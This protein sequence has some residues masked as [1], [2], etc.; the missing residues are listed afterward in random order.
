MHNPAPVQEND[1]HK[2]LWDFY[3][4]TDHLIS[5]IRP[6]KLVI[7]KKRICKIV[8]FA[9][10]ADLRIKLREYEKKAK[11]LDLAWESKE[12][13]E[14]KGDYYINRYWYFWYSN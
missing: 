14:H 1:T 6:H 13:V 10:P 5:T 8:E 3:I 4:L 2:F 11:Y 12:S 7:N 9:V